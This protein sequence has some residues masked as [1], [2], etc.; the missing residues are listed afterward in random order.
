[1]HQSM[2]FL[3]DDSNGSQNRESQEYVQTQ[4]NWRE[5][6]LLRIPNGKASTNSS[7]H[8]ELEGLGKTMEEQ[9]QEKVSKWYPYIFQN[10]TGDL[11]G[12]IIHFLVLVCLQHIYLIR[13]TVFSKFLLTSGYLIYKVYLYHN[14]Q[15]YLCNLLKTDVF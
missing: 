5:L 15:K 8:P 13:Y 2:N 7:E 12:I 4:D 11:Q 6:R 14:L 9:L 1:M 3:D 10:C